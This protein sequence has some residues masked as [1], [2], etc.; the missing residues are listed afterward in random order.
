MKYQRTLK[1]LRHLSAAVLLFSSAISPS[2][3]PFVDVIATAA[4]VSS[5]QLASGSTHDTGNHQFVNGDWQNGNNFTLSGS[6]V[7]N[8]AYNIFNLT[9]NAQSQLGYA[10]F[11]YQVNTSDSFSV[12]SNFTINPN[13]GNWDTAGDG[14]GF[15]L[16]PQSVSNFTAGQSGE[17]LGIGGIANAT[18]AGRDL[19][20]NLSDSVDGSTN[21]LGGWTDG[22]G[23]MIA[24]RNTNS[25]GAITHATYP[26]GTSNNTTNG[27]AWEQ[28]ANTA[29]AGMTETMTISWTPDS[30]NTASSGFVSGTLTYTNAGSSTYTLTTHT[31]LAQDTTIGMMGTTGNN[32]G[33]M[34]VNFG[35]AS[36]SGTKVTEPVTVN[37]VNQQTGQAISGLNPSTITANVGDT[38]GVIPSS[39]T[40]IN[41]SNTYDYIAPDVTGYTAVATSEKVVN[42]SN[43]I[44][45]QY[46]PAT[47]TASFSYGISPAVP[48]AGGGVAGQL[49]PEDLITTFTG[50]TM[51]TGVTD[52]TIT[53]PGVA[54]IPTFA[55]GYYV[56]VWVI[57]DSDHGNDTMF[58]SPTTTADVALAQAIASVT[59]PSGNPGTYPADIQDDQNSMGTNATIAFDIVLMPLPATTNFQFEYDPSTPGYNGNPGQTVP[60]LPDLTSFTQTGLT[61]SLLTDNESSL[62]ALP[63]GYH[64]SGVT[65]PSGITYDTMADALAAN[66]G[67]A[68]Q[69]SEFTYIVAPDM[70]Q[71]TFIRELS[72]DTPGYNGNPGQMESG[73]A[74]MSIGMPSIDNNISLPYGSPNMTGFPPG[75]G[76]AYGYTYHVIGP[77][78]TIY[79][80]DIDAMAAYPYVTSPL[81]FTLQYTA[82]SQSA[83][84]NFSY[85]SSIANP[86]AAPATVTENGATGGVIAD[87]TSQFTIP[88]GYKIESVTGPDGVS[89]PDVASCLAGSD[90]NQYYQPLHQSAANPDGSW[91]SMEFNIVLEL[92]G[93]ISL[94]SAPDTI[95]F[96]T[97]L[98]GA[99]GNSAIYGSLDDDVVVTDNRSA[100]NQTDWQVTLTQTSALTNG[101]VTLDNNMS[102]SDGSTATT[103]S[104]A[105]TLIHS[106]SSQSAGSY[107]LTTSWSKA[108]NVGLFLN[109]PLAQQS[110]GQYN[111]T[112]TWTLSTVPEN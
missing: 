64:I 92:D 31:T 38:I 60:S 21:I 32:Y 23:N 57:R 10:L 69:T 61:G 111:G 104:A 51:E 52:G 65:A 107:D 82:L 18:F 11:D 63:T 59:G 36:F 62:P 86:P 1:K 56:Q 3:I 76:G 97:N 33:I 54:N 112:L 77:D 103:L 15:I 98:I 22:P 45:V 101:I 94:D 2:M 72:P 68:A 19:Y 55:D 47:Q 27:Q 29:S 14:V 108:N 9:N 78:G 91:S 6:T 110:V 87:P 28:A 26:N 84:F 88:K 53:N 34:S 41:D 24:I 8:I 48:G 46:A 85:D 13:S 44:N 66:P 100:Q 73:M 79:D 42:G 12:N 35:S 40:T 37:Y 39:Q 90:T 95:D 67:M 74:G 89:Y 109:V 20:S 50:T 70:E 17:N 99:I 25:S 30:T 106:E 4:T 49:Q 16:I 83:D 5:G 96:G 75:T 105:Q 93:S 102:Y 81:T 7:P 71:L 58:G 43:V 80:T